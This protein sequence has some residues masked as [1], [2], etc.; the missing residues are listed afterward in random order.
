MVEAAELLRLPVFANLP[1]DQ[2]A[3][4]I[5]QSQELALQPDEIYVHEGDPADAMFVVLDG[6]LQVKGELAG[7]LVTFVSQPGD[8]TG[9]LPFSRMKQFPLTGRALAR[10]RVLRFP[11]AQFSVLVQKMPELTSRLVVKMSDR[12]RE[13]TQ[14]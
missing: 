11:A 10:S 7:G 2:I 4:F 1:E 5:S 8:V 13:A 14:D 6:Q 9:L 12:V 3:W